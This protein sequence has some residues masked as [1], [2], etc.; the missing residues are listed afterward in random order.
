MDMDVT[1][2]Y[3]TWS[4][5]MGDPEGKYDVLTGTKA[6]FNAGVAAALLHSDQKRFDLFFA[7]AL[8]GILARSTAG[9]LMSGKSELVNE[10]RRV[11]QLCMREGTG[12]IR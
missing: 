9:D 1:Q 5:S 12:E 7:A 11:A 4:K 2:L 10:A 6:A 3:L 8:Q